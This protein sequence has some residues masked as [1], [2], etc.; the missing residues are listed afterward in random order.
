MTPT[1]S[2]GRDPGGPPRVARAAARSRGRGALRAHLRS[3]V[4]SGETVCAYVPVGSE[5]GSIDLLDSL[6][7]AGVRVLLPVARTDAEACRC[8]CSGGVP[9]RRPGRCA[10]RI[11]RTAAALAAGRRGGRRGG[12]ARPGAGGRSHRCAPWPRRG[13]RPVAAAG[14]SGGAAGR[15]GPRR[16]TRRPPARRTARRADDPRADTGLG[17]VPLG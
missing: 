9:S 11:A 16:R 10:L 14:R 1:A 17:L 2:C 4:S 3:L 8:R 6:L 5:P 7:R 13:F 15:G 12:R